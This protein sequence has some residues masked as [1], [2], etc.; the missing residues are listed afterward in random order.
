LATTEEQKAICHVLNALHAAGDQWVRKGLPNPVRALNAVKSKF[1][2]IRRRE[3]ETLLMHGAT[4][5]CFADSDV[6]FL[7][8]PA[9]EG[10]AA[11]ALWCRWDYEQDP[12]RC[13]FYLG[14][15]SLQPPFPK[16]AGAPPG[17]H[18]AFVGY[19]FETPETGDNHNYYHAQP[20]RSMGPK[21]DEIETALP[22]SY[23]MPT[24]PI[25]ATCAL[26]LLLCSVASMYGMNGLRLLQDTL[27]GDVASRNNNLLQ[28]ALKAVFTLGWPKASQG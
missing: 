18:V 9:K 20:S 4:R 2:P 12:P 27:N 22:I 23:R 28:I 15:W 21:N 10:T 7:E 16:V 3:L 17:H 24:W 25:A 5:G 26:E 13:G 6:L 8:P 14:I 11:A 1:S 19:R